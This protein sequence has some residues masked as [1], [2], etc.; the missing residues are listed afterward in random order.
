MRVNSR[1]IDLDVTLYASFSLP[2]YRKD[3]DCWVKVFGY[4][5]GTK[6]CYSGRF[7]CQ[8]SACSE[9]FLSYVTGLWID[10]ERGLKELEGTPRRVAEEVVERYYCLSISAAPW[11]TMEILT[12]VFLSRNTDYHSNTVKWVRAL[13][14][15]ASRL[16][17]ESISPLEEA[18]RQV[19]RRFGS[20][21]L[22]QYAEVLGDLHAAALRATTEAPEMIRRALIRIKYV[23]PKVAN[24]FMLHSGLSEAAA[25]VDVHYVRFLKK[26]GL[27]DKPLSPPRKD[28]CSEYNCLSC[29]RRDACLYGYTSRLFGKLN[30][31]IQ[32]AAYVSGKLGVSKCSD[33]RKADLSSILQ[34][35]CPTTG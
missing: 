3:R 4:G 6:V 5:A 28:F 22:K 2:M 34:R 30:G 16:S 20:Y 31:F 21:Q 12:A 19:Y 11:D 17:I 23:G 33:I 35:C 1:E 32:T 7:E 8:G 27:L 15:I 18:V 10:K 13:L 25:P 24:A 29:P 9:K 26:Y 14:S